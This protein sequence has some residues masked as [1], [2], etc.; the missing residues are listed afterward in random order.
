MQCLKGY[1]LATQH[2]TLH[3]I[4]LSIFRKKIF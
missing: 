1:S 2:T 3:K 4:S